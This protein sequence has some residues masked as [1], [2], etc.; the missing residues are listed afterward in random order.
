MELIWEVTSGSSTEGQV[1]ETGEAKEPL[2]CVNEQTSTV[3]GETQT[4]RDHVE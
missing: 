2:Q 3:G 4:S 1:Y